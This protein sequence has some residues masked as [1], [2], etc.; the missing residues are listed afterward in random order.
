MVV[1]QTVR[2]GDLVL[3]AGAGTASTGILAA[4]KA[5]PSGS[6]TCLDLCDEMIA[7]AR[8]KVAR[9]ALATAI[10]F[11]TGDMCH[12]PFADNHFDVALSTYSLCPLYDPARGVLELYRVVKPGGRI[13]LAYSDTPEQP[14]MQWLTNKIERMA[15]LIPSLSMGCRAIDVLP[16]IQHTDARMIMNRKIGI[17]LWPFRVIIFEKSDHPLAV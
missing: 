5:A 17:P 3:D 14:F 16:A 1:E 7:V 12:L 13:G 8:E 15:W 10:N 11:T 9:E 6:V 2:P 4:R